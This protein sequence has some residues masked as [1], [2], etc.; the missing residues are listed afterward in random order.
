VALVDWPTAVRRLSRSHSGLILRR[1]RLTARSDARGHICAYTRE[2][3]EALGWWH[4]H[5]M[6]AWGGTRLARRRGMAHACPHGGSGVRGLAQYLVAVNRRREWRSWARPVL[7]AS[8]GGAGGY[9]HK[10]IGRTCTVCPCLDLLC[11]ALTCLDLICLDGEVW[12]RP[13][14]QW[15]RT[16]HMHDRS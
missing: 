12:G 13:G 2:E 15:P 9:I 4:T 16:P 6:E 10:H 3:E 7:V 8:R 1:A 11:L 5:A 14:R